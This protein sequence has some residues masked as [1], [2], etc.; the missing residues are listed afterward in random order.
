MKDKILEL[1]NSGKS[2]REIRQILGCSHSLISYYVNPDGKTKQ[3]QRQN[4]NRFIKREKYKLSMG[5]KC[6]KCGYDRCLAALHFH[7]KN[8]EEKKFLL[9]SAMWGVNS[10]TEEDILNE[11]KKCDLICANCHAEYH[12]PNT[13]K[14]W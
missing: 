5:G 7:H 1:H 10:I 12:Y 4:K 2:Y 3:L 8:P 9:S 11:I 14:K 6:C 13:L